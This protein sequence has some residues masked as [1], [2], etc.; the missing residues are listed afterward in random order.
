[1]PTCQPSAHFA[2]WRAA[3]TATPTTTTTKAQHNN[4][5]KA[6]VVPQGSS[7]RRCAVSEVWGRHSQWVPP[8]HAQAKRQA[9]P[10]K[11]LHV[12]ATATAPRAIQAEVPVKAGGRHQGLGLRDDRYLQEPRCV[13]AD[14]VPNRRQEE[15]GWDTW[16]KR[17]RRS[18]AT[19]LA[20]AQSWL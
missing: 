4:A 6:K 20:A 5:A 3:I 15:E 16:S 9:E 2:C 12:E 7:L 1:M 14:K 11:K 18:A 17:W 13:V 19:A 8:P 10:T